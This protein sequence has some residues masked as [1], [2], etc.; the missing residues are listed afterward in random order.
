M[1][2][3][4]GNHK[5]LQ[6]VFARVM[7]PVNNQRRRVVKVIV[8]GREISLAHVIGV[9]EASIYKNLGLDIGTNAGAD[10]TGMSI[11]TVHITPPESTIIAADI[12]VKSGDVIIGFMDRFSGTLILTGP[13]IEVR[14][15]VEEIVKYF[16]EGLN[17]KTCPVT[18]R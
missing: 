14:T 3:S 5:E 4:I 10:F 11:G 2:D 9:S 8:A 18:E 15:A 7:E 1:T 12:A 6:E 17:Y 13:R 16:R